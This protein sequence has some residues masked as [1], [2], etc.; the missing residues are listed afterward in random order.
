M[1]KNT[2]DASLPYIEDIH[3][4][5]AARNA[6]Y[7]IRGGDDM[8]SS[9][10]E[11]AAREMVEA[12]DVERY[13]RIALERSGF[14][15]GDGVTRA[16]NAAVRR[17]QRGEGFFGSVEYCAGKENV[18]VEDVKERV[19]RI[20]EQAR[21]KDAER[22]YKFYLIKGHPKDSVNKRYN[23]KYGYWQTVRAYTEENAR[24]NIED[25]LP[26]FLFGTVLECVSNEEALRRLAHIQ[27]REQQEAETAEAKAKKWPFGRKGE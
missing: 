3:L 5:Y 19:E 24:R 23:N 9:I 11:C 10:R 12:A 18:S 27:K 21:S 17:I 13:V 2:R 25:L 4:Y 26:G 1:A 16:A 20:M 8:E 6:L 14:E 7:R 15:I 22:V